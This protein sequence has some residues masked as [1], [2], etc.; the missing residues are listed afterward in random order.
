MIRHLEMA[1][2]RVPEVYLHSV[3]SRII[4]NGKTVAID[5]AEQI[6]ACADRSHRQQEEWLGTLFDQASPSS[7]V[8]PSESSSTKRTQII[9]E[10]DNEGIT[11]FFL[12]HRQCLTFLRTCIHWAETLDSKRKTT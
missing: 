10:D 12:G 8:Y 1:P 11:S 7:H 9:I 2:Q 6:V 5:R 4:A 3:M